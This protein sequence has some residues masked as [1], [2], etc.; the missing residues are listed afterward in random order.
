MLWKDAFECHQPPDSFH[1][2]SQCPRIVPGSFLSELFASFQRSFNHT[3][4]KNHGQDQ[5]DEVF[6]PP[7]PP[8]GEDHGDPEQQDMLL[9]HSEHHS[10]VDLVS[11]S[12]NKTI[13]QDSKWNVIQ[14]CILSN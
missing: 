13:K 5:T 1:Q 8:V 14:M 2:M 4:E 9:F 7:E 10:A 3:S 6:S 12:I 11:I